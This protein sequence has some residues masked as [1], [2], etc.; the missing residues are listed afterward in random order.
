[1]EFTGGKV[2]TLRC[3]RS[4][5]RC[6]RRASISL[7]DRHIRKAPEEQRLQRT[8]PG[9]IVVLISCAVCRHSASLKT[10][11]VVGVDLG[12]RH[13]RNNVAVKHFVLA[14]QLPTVPSADDGRIRVLLS[15]RPAEIRYP[16]RITQPTGL[17]RPGTTSERAARA[18]ALMAATSLVRPSARGVEV[19]LRP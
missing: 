8:L 4:G 5:V 13:P 14:A 10:K 15:R 7:E 9:L 6:V 11:I 18:A 3:G 17:E 19:S 12:D 16:C 1:V 2:S